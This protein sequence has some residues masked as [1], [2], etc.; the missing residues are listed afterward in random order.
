MMLAV[1]WKFKELII[2]GIVLAVVAGGVWS[3]VSAYKERDQYRA[4][5]TLL[6]KQHAEEKAAWG[7]EVL[8]WERQVLR[9][10]QEL[11]AV[12][13]AKDAIIRKERRKFEE[14][15]KE[16][17]KVE[18]H[19]ETQTQASVQIKH[20][21]V[22]VPP[23]FVRLYNAVADSSQV[24]SA[25]GRIRIPDDPAGIVGEVETYDATT[26]TNIVLG[27]AIE[28]VAL[29]ARHN[30]LVDIVVA[31][32]ATTKERTAPMLLEETHDH[33]I[34]TTGTTQEGGGNLP[35]RVIESLF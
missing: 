12:K 13:K 7:Q 29:A 2:A 22:S 8:K 35:N 4:E 19:V 14:I 17:K 30:A 10:Q 15:F 24:A 27:N 31:F 23:D 32:E 34:R 9:Q 20:G 5:V 1:L 33:T 21:V 25:G 6:K 28:C 18:T 3:V 16:T 11:D 26:F